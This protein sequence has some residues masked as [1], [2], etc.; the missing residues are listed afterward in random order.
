LQI[1]E[2]NDATLQRHD[3]HPLRSTED[4][5]AADAEA[6]RIARDIVESSARVPGTV[7]A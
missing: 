5:L 3:G 1:A 7:S 2:V 4:V 6:R